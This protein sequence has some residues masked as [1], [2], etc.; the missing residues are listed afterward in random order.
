MTISINNFASA[1]GTTLS[2]QHIAS[3][4][5]EARRAMGY[6]IDELAVTTGLVSDEILR[7]ESGMDADP[8]KLKRIAAALQVPISTFLLT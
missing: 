3:A 6:S 5:A 7:V 4:V 2:P 8:A 1:N